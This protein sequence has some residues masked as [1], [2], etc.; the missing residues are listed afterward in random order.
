MFTETLENLCKASVVKRNLL[1]ESRG[2]YFVASI[3]AGLYVGLGIFLIMTVGGLTKPMGAHFRIFIGLAFGVAL[4]LVVMAGSELFTGNNLIM[5]AGAANRDVSWKDAGRIWGMSYLGNLVGSIIAGGLFIFSGAA[6]PGSPVGEFI[7]NL[8]KAKMS[9]APASLIF[10]GILC[11]LLVCLA[12]LCCIKMKEEGAKLIMVF[13]CLFAFITSGYEHSIANMS[14][15]TAGLMYP[16]ASGVSLGGAVS[17]LLW[18]TF[19]NF[20]GGSVLG[21][22]YY[23]MGKKKLCGQGEIKGIYR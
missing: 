4:S 3:L 8:S 11:N 6:A 18:V 2:K 13:W 17:N 20:I 9:G 22:T 12:V 14:I 1:D 10:K 21:L 23:Y 15:F 16:A 7:V 5:A 19:G